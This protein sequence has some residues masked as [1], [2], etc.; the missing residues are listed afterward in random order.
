M[1]TQ[2]EVQ[3]ICY[4]AVLAQAERHMEEREPMLRGKCR[5]CAYC[6]WGIDHVDVSAP[7]AE[8]LEESVGIC[9]G[10]MSLCIVE[11]DSE[12]DEGCWEEAR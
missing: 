7:L 10:G 8:V 9:D 11:L 12:H 2:E 3:G 4:D 1:Q 6:R 5:D